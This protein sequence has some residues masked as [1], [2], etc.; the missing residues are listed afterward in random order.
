MTLLAVTAKLVHAP[1][2][3]DVTPGQ[4]SQRLQRRYRGRRTGVVAIVNNHA[5]VRAR[6]HLH[7]PGKRL[8][9]FHAG[10][11]LLRCQPQL[12]AHCRRRGQGRQTVPPDHLGLH[13]LQLTIIKS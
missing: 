1:D 8:H 7:A 6:K 11:Y 12:L 3:G 2:N 9:G 4:L 5:V 10:L 13:P